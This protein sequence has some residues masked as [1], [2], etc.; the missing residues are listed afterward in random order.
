MNGRDLIYNRSLPRRTLARRK[1]IWLQRASSTY[2]QLV[3]GFLDV[4]ILGWNFS[5]GLRRFKFLPGNNTGWRQCKPYGHQQRRKRHE[6]GNSSISLL[7]VLMCALGLIPTLGRGEV[8]AQQPKSEAAQIEQLGD[9]FEAMML[10]LL[11]KQMQQSSEFANGDGPFAPSSAEKIFRGMKDE[12]MVK[13]IAG[14]R[15]LGF[16]DTVVRHIRGQGGIDNRPL[17]RPNRTS[18]KPNL[19]GDGG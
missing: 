14:G 9:D 7:S 3:E 19:A 2:E 5:N 4:G 8:T 13:K 17:V 18:P 12:E 1:Q 6:T 10:Q 16:G 15:P 11:F